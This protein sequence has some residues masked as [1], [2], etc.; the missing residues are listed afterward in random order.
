MLL[1]QDGVLLMSDALLNAGLMSAQ[2]EV[3]LFLSLLL[4]VLQRVEVLDLL[5]LGLDDIELEVQLLSLLLG[6]RQPRLQLV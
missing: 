6:H 5:K 1:H 3:E 4:P 2:F